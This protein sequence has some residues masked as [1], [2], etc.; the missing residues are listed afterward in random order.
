MTGADMT[1]P[2]QNLNAS[3]NVSMKDDDTK[4]TRARTVE[5]ALCHV[6]RRSADHHGAVNTPVYHAST[7]LFPTL[8]DHAD[9]KS[10]SVRYGRRGTPTSQSLE[11]A[12]SVLEQAAGTVLAPSGVS[13]ISVALLAHARPDARYLVA[14]NVYGPCRAFCQ[15]VLARLGVQ[16]EFFDPAIGADIAGLIDDDTRLIWMEAPGSQT[17]E[18]TDI[19]AIAAVARDHGV[20]SVVDNTWSGGL[21]C[22]PLALGADVSIQA[23]TKYLSGH[24]DLMMGTLACSDAALPLIRDMAASMGLCVGPDDAFMM[25]RGMR[26]LSVRLNQHQA[27]ALALADWLL[28]RPEVIRVMHPALPQDPGHALWRDQFSGSSGLFGFVIRDVPR[29][30]LAAMMDG[31]E[32]FGMGASW[33]GYESLLIP[34]D[35]CPH[36]SATD[37]TPGGQTMRIHVGLENPDELIEDLDRGFARMAAA[38]ANGGGA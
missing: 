11:E 23:G 28:T 35:P 26:T 7:I 5:T 14:D 18:M 34:T 37:W 33:G 38:C 6:G 3:G 27:G 4:S 17:F 36:R 1:R 9:R 30:A 10:K 20:M 8:A 16:T 12:V 15:N 2:G 29:P 19:R 22:Q 25:L 13:A 31:L 24:S 21:F 32:L